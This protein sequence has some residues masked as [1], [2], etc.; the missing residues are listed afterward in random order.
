MVRAFT[1][2]YLR[3]RPKVTAARPPGDD[4]RVTKSLAPYDPKTDRSRLQRYRILLAAQTDRD[5]RAMLEQLI[6]ETEKRLAASAL[7]A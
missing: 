1:Y 2:D 3:C 5:I 7:P 6:G 4:R